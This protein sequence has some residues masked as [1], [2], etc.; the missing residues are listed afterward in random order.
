MLS[1]IFE[2]GFSESSYGFQPGRN[3]HQAVKAAKR[4]VAEGR[5]VV[6]DMDLEKTKLQ[7]RLTCA[8]RLSEAAGT[9]FFDRVNYDLLMEQLSKK[10]SDGRVLRLKTHEPSLSEAI[11]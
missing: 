11:L 4:Y 5:R 3:A 6:V 1:P 7:R 2:A 8:S 9:K 10:I